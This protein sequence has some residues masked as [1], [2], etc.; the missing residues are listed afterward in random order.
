MHQK[1]ELLSSLYSP[2]DLCVFPVFSFTVSPFAVHDGSVDV[3][4]RK[5]VGFIQQRDDAQQDGSETQ[6]RS[7][8]TITLMLLCDAFPLVK[9]SQDLMR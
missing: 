9:T 8:N 1:H 3:S 7:Y 4:R 2:Y 5:C 6:T